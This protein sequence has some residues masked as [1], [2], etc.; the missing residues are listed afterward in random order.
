LLK[1]QVRRGLLE[2]VAVKRFVLAL[3]FQGKYESGACDHKFIRGPQPSQIVLSETTPDKLGFHSTIA[4]AE[5]PFP[6]QKAPQLGRELPWKWNH[7]S[8]SLAFNPAGISM[9]RRLL[10]GSPGSL[11][12]FTPRLA[13]PLRIQVAACWFCPYVTWQPCRT[14]RWFLGPIT[15]LRQNAPLGRAGMNGEESPPKL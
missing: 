15:L 6:H 13:M 12:D 10:G 5:Y 1:A 11:L 4:P 14:T 8:S 9:E 7:S 2:Y 3:D